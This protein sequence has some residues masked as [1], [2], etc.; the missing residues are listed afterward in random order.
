MAYPEDPFL[1]FLSS[2]LPPS[3]FSGLFAHPYF[4]RNPHCRV[5]T[6]RAERLVVTTRQYFSCPGTGKVS[7]DSSVNF[8][9]CQTN[10]NTGRKTYGKVPFPENYLDM[11]PWEYAHVDMVLGSVIQAHR[12]E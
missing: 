6:V 12:H 5:L 8:D 3:L 4:V 11:D 10:K 1:S 7:A 9:L 2:C